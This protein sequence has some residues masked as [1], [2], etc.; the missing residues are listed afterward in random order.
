MRYIVWIESG[1]YSDRT[2]IV[3]STHDTEESAESARRALVGKYVHVDESTWEYSV[4]DDPD[5]HSLSSPD[6]PYN[7]TIRDHQPPGHEPWAARWSL[8]PSRLGHGGDD[9]GT[10]AECVER[11]AWWRKR[12]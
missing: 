9:P 5:E 2:I 6:S 10:D 12:T 1:C 4:R 8:V 11:D 7:G 3:V